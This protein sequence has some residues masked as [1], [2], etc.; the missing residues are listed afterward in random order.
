VKKITTG[1]ALSCISFC[2]DG[3]TIAVGSEL[4]GRALVYDLKDPKKIKIE[5]KGHDKT[6]RINSLVF[7]KVYKPSSATA[8]SSTTQS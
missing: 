4:T 2:S 7:T 6:K 8:P 5:L 3:H 1:I